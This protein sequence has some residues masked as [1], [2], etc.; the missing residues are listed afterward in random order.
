M[1][2][3]REKRYEEVRAEP[4]LKVSTRYDVSSSFMP[5]GRMPP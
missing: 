1:S 5:H 2:V 3:S 4:M